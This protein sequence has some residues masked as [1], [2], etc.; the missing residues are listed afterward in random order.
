MTNAIILRKIIEV[1]PYR[2]SERPNSSGGCIPLVL[3][4]GH[5]T[6]RNFTFSY[7]VGDDAR[8]FECEEKA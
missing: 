1:Q 4:C 2:Q 5:V 6:E 8:C 7:R 3:E